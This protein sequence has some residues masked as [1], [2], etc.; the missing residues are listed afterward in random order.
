MK[1]QLTKTRMEFSALVKTYQEPLYWHIR[2]LVVSHEDARDVLQETF[3]QA[4]RGIGSLRE[5]GAL[6]A[7][8]YKIA[9]HEAYRFLN[10]QRER[11]L[12]TEEVSALLLGRLESS[13]YVDYEQ[14]AEVKFQQ[15]LLTLSEQQRAVFTLRYYDEMPYDEIAEV[16]DST[17]ASLRVSY[18]HAEQRIRD[19]LKTH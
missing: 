17:P 8:L 12:S 2:R 11:P 10:R 16:L 15:A 1:K 14:E 18:H 6:R 5:E 9:T 7:W 13:S 3:V 4:W 19:Y